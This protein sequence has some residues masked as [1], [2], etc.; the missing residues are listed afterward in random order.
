MQNMLRI[1]MTALLALL[2]L[3]LLL[4]A[5]MLIHDSGLSILHPFEMD[6]GEGPLLAQ[7]K[8]L[9]QGQWPYFSLTQAD[10]YVVA[11]YPPL[12]H[13]LTVGLAKLIGQPLLL[14]GR[15]LA[16]L[17]T[18][19]A[20]VIL[21]A[22]A[23]TLVGHLL[24][25]RFAKLLVGG[26]A[27][28]G[29]LSLDYV[30]MWS[31]LFR[32]DMLAIA[33][34]YG[35][36]FWFAHRLGRLDGL[37]LGGLLM[38]AACFTKQSY[39]AAPAACGLVLLVQRPGLAL[40][41]GLTMVAAGLALLGGL[42]AVTHGAI[43][44]NLVTANINEFILADL[45]RY[46]TLMLRDNWLFILGALAYL[47]LGLRQ[48]RRLSSD[49]RVLVLY[50]PLAFI[51]SLS[52]GKIGSNFNYFIE[53]LGLAVVATV[54]L[55]AWLLSRSPAH[56][57]ATGAGSLLL[58]LA[59]AFTLAKYQGD[60][61]WDYRS[62]KVAIGER[63]IHDEQAAL[64][65]LTQVLRWAEQQQGN[66]IAEDMTLLSESG[67]PL[68]LQP[69]EETQLVR[70]GLW[71]ELPL[72]SQVLAGQFAGL[73][74]FFD[75]D[76]VPDYA[77]QRFTDPM[78]AAMRQAYE[79]QSQVGKYHLYV[80]KPETQK[81][82]SA[83]YNQ[84]GCDEM[85]GPLSEPVRLEGLADWAG[86][87]CLQYQGAQ[88]YTL[89]FHG[90]GKALRVASPALHEVP[91][92]ADAP[93][94]RLS[95]TEFELAPLGEG[96]YEFILQRQGDQDWRVS[97]RPSPHVILHMPDADGHWETS[98]IYAEEN[99]PGSEI[100]FVPEQETPFFSE[101]EANQY[102]SRSQQAAKSSQTKVQG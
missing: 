85:P 100:W 26:L 63:N 40:G 46:L 33:L 64:P 20:G 41:W 68:V 61:Q 23:A 53:W 93:M 80:P 47:C 6:Y 35:G 96:L 75:L 27:L 31:G 32:V 66:L 58:L 56:R 70:Q 34:A 7:S 29:F 99:L 39:L 15:L 57:L 51:T 91:V 11:N 98:L 74:L 97:V 43:W 18:L 71:H 95:S 87:S 92:A 94:R 76:E 37:V 19:A 83:L 4:D 24:P 84:A 50:L 62:Q 17:S 65:E 14:A 1:G 25:N 36:A 78:L 28:T 44:D 89:L 3:S 81:T 45:L 16:L 2:C 102:L 10:Q 88:R 42:M 12:F 21:A 9:Q 67:H 82:A 49:A 60:Y 77:H 79:K 73:I 5:G 55:G 30:Y 101:A 22:W 86:Q 69:F 54:Q 59:G 52:I 48:F 13:L 90:Q 38:L 72:R 8:L